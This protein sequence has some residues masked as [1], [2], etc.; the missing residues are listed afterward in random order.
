MNDEIYKK[1]L[2]MTKIARQIR[3]PESVK[4]LVEMTERFQKNVPKIDVPSFSQ[5]VNSKLLKSLEEFSRIAERI[6]DNPE[7]HFAMISDLEALNLKSTT[8]LKKR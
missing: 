1:A 7:F 5:N 4:K 3:I 8:D 6:N 2:E